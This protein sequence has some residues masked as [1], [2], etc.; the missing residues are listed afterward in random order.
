MSDGS[1]VVNLNG[2]HLN[3]NKDPKWAVEDPGYYWTYPYNPCKGF[4]FS[5]DKYNQDG[6]TTQVNYNN[7]AV[8]LNVLLNVNMYCQ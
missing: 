7:L 8:S 4:S 6:T 1:G 5:F 3:A 2:I